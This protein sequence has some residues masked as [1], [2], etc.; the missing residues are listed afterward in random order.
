LQAGKI[1]L[2]GLAISLI[3]VE[4]LAGDH[5]SQPLAFYQRFLSPFNT[6]VT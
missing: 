2:S 4:I 6:T 5:R 1:Y 3:A